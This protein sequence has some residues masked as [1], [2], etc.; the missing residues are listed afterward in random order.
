VEAG[1]RPRRRIQE[2][3]CRLRPRC[4]GR[5][6]QRGKPGPDPALERDFLEITGGFESCLA[7]FSRPRYLVAGDL[8]V[9]V[10]PAAGDGCG[11]G[12][13]L[14]ER[15]DAH[16]DG[17]HDLLGAVQG[18]AVEMEVGQGDQ[19][20]EE[21][22]GGGG[23]VASLPSV[24]RAGLTPPLILSLGNA[25]PAGPSKMT[26]LDGVSFGNS[27]QGGRTASGS[28]GDREGLPG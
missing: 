7:H 11:G 12:R 13:F 16:A 3:G 1:T 4:L 2:R 22:C 19:A 15:D 24:K 17:G 8:A 25:R 26:P 23:L 18:V 10:R 9:A 21:R 5:W 14:P 20:R 28:P 27:W 6:L